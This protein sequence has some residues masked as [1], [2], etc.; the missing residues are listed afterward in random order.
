MILLNGPELSP[1]NGHP[2]TSMVVIMH[3]WGA[4]GPNLIDLAYAMA[5]QLPG[6]HF[7]SP[8]APFVC[9]DIPSGRQWFSLGNRDWSRLGEHINTP[10]PA[11][12]LFID[13]HLKALGLTHDRLALVGFSQ[14]TMT[15]L[16][17]ALHQP[18]QIAGVVG[19]SGCL[20]G[21]NTLA[22]TIVSHPPVCLIH[23]TYDDVVP[24][25]AMAE[26]EAALTANDVPVETHAIAGLAHGIHPTGLVL[27]QNR[28][29]A[30]LHP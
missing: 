10:I 22:S 3:G 28:L 18:Q 4:D 6:T 12:Q 26:A 20:I 14:G 17:Y 23:G 11:L 9:D 2:A 13:H 15:A 29:K 16:H 21:G 8:N 30:W 27:A 1:Q 7:F 25:S 19:F 5:P 24:F